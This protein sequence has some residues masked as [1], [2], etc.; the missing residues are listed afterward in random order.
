MTASSAQGIVATF[1]GTV[2]G[3]ISNISIT[4]G[5]IDLDETDLSHTRENHQAGITTVSGTIDCYGAAES[6]LGGIGN[7]VLSGTRT[8]DYGDCICLNIAAGAAVK[9]LQTTQY[10]FASSVDT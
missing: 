5:V 1:D 4:E 8:K 6:I 10:T 9:G 3:K 2:L 7:L